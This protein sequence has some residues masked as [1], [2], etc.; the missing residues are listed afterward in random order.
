MKSNALEFSLLNGTKL[1][2]Q[3]VHIEN[4][5]PWPLNREGT[6]E[7]YY[8]IDH[9]GGRELFHVASRSPNKIERLDLKTAVGAEHWKHCEPYLK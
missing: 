2:F 9:D 7:D 4:P 5:G 8:V 3:T 1:K 6:T